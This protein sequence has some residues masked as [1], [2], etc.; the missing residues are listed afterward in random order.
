L[1]VQEISYDEV[2]AAAAGLAAEGKPVSLGN[3]RE[4]LGAVP[5][6]ALHAHLAAWRSAQGE[7]AAALDAT[8]PADVATAL[9]NWARQLAEDA[10]GRVQQRLSQSESDLDALLQSNDRAESERAD[11]SERLAALAAERDQALARVSER[12]ASIDR[13]TAELRHARDVASEAL[14]GKAKDQLAI[15]GKDAQL[16]DLRQQLERHVSNSAAL[17]DARLAAE[18]ELVGATTARNNLAAEVAELRAQLDARRL[19]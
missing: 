19:G 4:V 15:D 9:G 11:L 14:V 7:P 10:A 17:S 13:L 18:M 1:A 12:D 8:L 6:Q 3:L 16:A 2:A 5:A